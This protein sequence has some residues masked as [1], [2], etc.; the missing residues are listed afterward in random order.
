M[1]AEAVWSAPPLLMTVVF[2]STFMLESVAGN[3][4]ALGS[5]GLN[6]HR[7]AVGRNAPAIG[8]LLFHRRPILA[9]LLAEEGGAALQL[10]EAVD[11]VLNAD[12]AIEPDIG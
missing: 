6:Q 11:A 4:E 9:D 10:L 8:G 7:L 1:N 2:R 12:P 3:E 5:G